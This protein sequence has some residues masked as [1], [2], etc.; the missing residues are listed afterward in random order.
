MNKYCYSTHYLLKL[1]NEL[2]PFCRLSNDKTIF[3]L[4]FI[5]YRILVVEEKND[6]KY[7]NETVSDIIGYRVRVSIII[8]TTKKERQQKQNSK[9]RNRQEESE[10][11]EDDLWP[12]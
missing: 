12:S 5:Q 3:F 1:G 7:R 8:D 11:T 9:S 4:L 6:W 10:W 2:S